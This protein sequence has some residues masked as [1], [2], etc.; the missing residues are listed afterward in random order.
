MFFSD[1]F[2]YG[3]QPADNIR[4]T[5]VKV[6]HDRVMLLTFNND[7]QRLFDTTVLDGE[8]FKRL[9]EEDVFNSAYI[10]HGV[11]TWLDGEI[12][13]SPEYMY[14]NSYEYTPIDSSDEAAMQGALVK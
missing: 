2:V 10:D 14:E 9:D 12:D 8:A 7:E 4:V 3:G 1:G 11:V 5:K 6:L 13:C